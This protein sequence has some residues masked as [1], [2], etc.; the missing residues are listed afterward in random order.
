MTALRGHHLVCLHFYRG[1]GYS[2]SFVEALDALMREA[3]AAG[4]VVCEGPDD[5]C[6][7][8]PHL[9]GERCAYAGD[10]DETV[11]EM[12]DVAR[13][14][15]RLPAGSPVAWD[16]VRERV[17]AMFAQWRGRFCSACDWRGACEKD[18]WYAALSAALSGR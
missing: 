2:A 10:A 5:V 13:A 18:G 15:L 4:V 1:E 16:D 12:D 3:A 14:L 6:H 11:R 9:S 17:P 8:C 7:R